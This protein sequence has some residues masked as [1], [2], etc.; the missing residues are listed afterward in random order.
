[1][2]RIR[3]T[4]NSASDGVRWGDFLTSCVS[5]EGALKSFAGNSPKFMLQNLVEMHIFEINNKQHQSR[6]T[7]IQGVEKQ[8]TEFIKENKGK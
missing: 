1:M 5:V 3:Y 4:F 7:L 2:I 8:I 6:E